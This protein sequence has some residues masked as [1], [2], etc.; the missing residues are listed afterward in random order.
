MQNKKDVDVRYKRIAVGKVV[1][2]FNILS[3]TYEILYKYMFIW[4]I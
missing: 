1:I 4:I 3:Y 2:L